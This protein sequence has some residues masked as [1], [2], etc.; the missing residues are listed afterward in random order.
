MSL[1]RS[2]LLLLFC[3]AG[4]P[5][6]HGADSYWKGTMTNSFW[7]TANNW[8]PPAVPRD[9]GDAAWFDAGAAKGCTLNSSVSPTTVTLLAGF[10]ET[11]TITGL[12]GLLE[13]EEFFLT[14]GTVTTTAMDRF[15]VSR[16]LHM[17]GGTLAEVTCL[18]Q[19]T[20]SGGNLGILRMKGEA[21]ILQST[22][23][24]PVILGTLVIAN[25][26]TL[27]RHLFAPA[28]FQSH[29]STTYTLEQ[30]SSLAAARHL[31]EG[32]VVLRPA[33]A[34]TFLSDDPLG[35]ST[36]LL[37]GSLLVFSQG[38]KITGTL[39]TSQGGSAILCN[40]DWEC[41]GEYRSSGN[42]SSVLT[43]NQKAASGFV[44]HGDNPADLVVIR[45]YASGGL[46]TQWRSSNTILG[47]TLTSDT[48][49]ALASG[50]RLHVSG[51]IINPG[52]IEV[53][54]DALLAHPG[55]LNF[56]NMPGL[57]AEVFE[58]GSPVFLRLRDDDQN[59]NG[60]VREQIGSVIIQNPRNGDHL[61]LTLLETGAAS[62]IFDSG[63]IPTVWADE[64]LDD[65]SIQ[66]VPGDILV[67]LY[68][69]PDDPDDRT[70]DTVFAASAATATPSPSPSESPSPSP[71]ATPS[72]TETAV[73]TT[74]PTQSP[75]F[76]PT[77]SPT[78][79]V[80]PSPSPTLSPTPGPAI[81]SDADGY[82][83]WYET[84]TGHDP[85]DAGEKPVLGDVDGDGQATVRDALLLYRHVS[86]RLVVAD[87]DC[88]RADCD[89]DGFCTV[90]DAVGLYRWAVRAKGYEI[91]PIP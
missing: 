41:P 1:F 63:P 50:V 27:Q 58:P 24:K 54:P 26:S 25:G 3:M 69:D 43:I 76:S 55:R 42:L 38:A 11:L 36:L 10:A 83:D 72:I 34:L 4:N 19:A 2:L 39:E 68:T 56:V 28:L 88:T 32:S 23:Y 65:D 61:A 60:T 89:L 46:F 16:H 40:G 79:S 5:M 64:A 7:N 84:A 47:L 30:L 45:G 29:A 74:T 12:N 51:D 57:D 91:L 78:P 77:A 86:G 66:A 37:P 73:P 13:C 59:L 8:S 35:G 22:S 48:L 53:P 21:G 17:N 80:S 85:F 20:L 90:R 6:V 71:S 31:V 14:S 70:S 62:R 81:D 52:V 49:L 87:F 9:S 75:T 15:Q 33:S 44:D 18:G 82:A 67:A